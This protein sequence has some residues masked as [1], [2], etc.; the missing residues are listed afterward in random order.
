MKR[1]GVRLASA[2]SANDT[3][4]IQVFTPVSSE[5]LFGC[6]VFVLALAESEGIHVSQSAFKA[7]VWD[8]LRQQHACDHVIAAA[9]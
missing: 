1:N 5:E 3:V 2:V 9:L 7:N 6:F 8:S 4:A